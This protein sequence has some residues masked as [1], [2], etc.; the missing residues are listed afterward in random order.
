MSRK[1]YD[2]AN[3]SESLG[4]AFSAIRGS[5]LRSILTLL[6]IAVGVFSIIAVMTAIGVLRNAIEEGITQLGANTFQ[7]QKFPAGFDSGHEERRR[8]RNRKDITFEQAERVREQATYAEAVGIESWQFGRIAQWG[9]RRTNPN[10]QIAG[11]N[12]DGLVTN[13]F[14]VGKGRG[15]T[16][17]DM[18]MGRKV[19][20]LGETIAEKL[21]PAYVDPLG[22]TVR[23]DGQLYVVIGIFEK[24]GTALGDNQDN[25]AAIPLTTYFG[26]YGKNSRS[27]NIMVKALDREVYDD[28]LDQSRAILRA[29]RHVPPGQEDDF[30]YFSNEGMI[31]Q[32]NEITSGFRLG[33]LLISSIALL[34]AGV[35]IMNIML[36]SVTERTR[37]IGIR[38]AVGAQRKDILSQFIIEAVLLSQIGGVIGVILGALGG[39]VVSILMEVPAV[40]PWDWAFIGLLVCSAVGLSFGVYPAWKAATLDPI[41]AL[42]YE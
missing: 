34:A 27:V 36:V 25:F 31:T 10:V 4:M 14:V 15:F 18:D 5:K 2:W 6:G 33:A 38:K 21:F 35:G 37:E 28:C 40:F 3:I 19:I 8:L 39:N 17:Q 20:I 42:R 1:F 7:I 32:F 24:K 30:A 11:E 22:Q 12:L 29:A 13:N 26:V 9:G 16:A 23:I 41:E